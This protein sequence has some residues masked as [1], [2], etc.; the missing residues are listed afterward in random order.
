[1]NKVTLYKWIYDSG[2]IGWSLWRAPEYEPISLEPARDGGSEEYIL[3]DGFH[4]REIFPQVPVLFFM[5][6]RGGSLETQEDGQ[7]AIRLWGSR[8]FPLQRA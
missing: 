5:G 6:R 4:L 7:P 2:E 1:M 3:P 8:I